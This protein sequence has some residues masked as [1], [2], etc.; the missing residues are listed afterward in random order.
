MTSKL[1]AS[2]FLATSLLATPFALS[3]QANAAE[4][5]AF[6]KGHSEIIMGWNHAGVSDQTA[7]FTDFS[8]TVVLDE[9]NPDKSNV[10]VTIKVDSLHTG[11]GPLDTELKGPGFLNEKKHPEITFKSTAVNRTGKNTADVAGNLTI[12]GVT[13]PAT[14]AVQ[15]IHLGD[16]PL[17][18]FIDYYAGKWA[19]FKATTSLNRSDFDV[20]AFA[21]LTSDRIDVSINV[22]LK[23]K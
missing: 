11:F 16:H 17:A 15:L 2:A 4:S 20:G 7:E 3:S 8:G 5:F 22:E 1:L 23:K 21:P 13:K 9:E 12:N 10:T 6:D 19:G 18:P 14:L